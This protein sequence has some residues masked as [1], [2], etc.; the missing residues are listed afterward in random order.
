MKIAVS[1]R[2]VAAPTYHEPRDAISHDWVRMFE[3]FS[4]TPVFIPNVLSDPVAYMREVGAKGLILT[5]GEDIGSLLG[6]SLQD[7]SSN[8]RDRTETFLMDYAVRERVPVFGVCR[9]FQLINQYFEGML[10]R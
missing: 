1:M 10:E 8:V 2:I 4:I 3:L 7:P 5:G 6:K 9:G